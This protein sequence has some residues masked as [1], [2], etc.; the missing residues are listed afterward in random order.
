MRH[1]RLRSVAL[2]I[3][4]SRVAP[5]KLYF[6]PAFSLTLALAA[7]LSG[8]SFAQ[9]LPR[10][11]SFKQC[12]AGDV[13]V[14]NASEGSPAAACPTKNLSRYVNYSLTAATFGITEHD[15]TGGEARIFEKMREDAG[16]SSYRQA[17]IRCWPLQAGERVTI[18]EYA[19]YGMVKVSPIR[20]GNPYWTSANHL[21]RR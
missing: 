19:D 14:T 6:K 1:S 4:A 13:V 9:V 8:M 21:D 2:A 5:S 18:L 20:G 10:V 16:V 17:A 15:V 11:C 7:T 12:A 3:R